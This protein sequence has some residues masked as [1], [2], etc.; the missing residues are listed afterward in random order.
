[1]LLLL[2]GQSVHFP[3]PK[4]VYATDLVITLD[5]TLPIFATGKASIEYI[6]H[7]CSPVNLL[8]IFRIPFHKNTSGQLLL[9]TPNASCTFSLEIGM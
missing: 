2:K 1:M 3:R 9:T 7:G 4:N 6:G 8:R 5:N